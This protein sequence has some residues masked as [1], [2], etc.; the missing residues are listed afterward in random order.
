MI[1]KYKVLN[2]EVIQFDRYNEAKTDNEKMKNIMK[3]KL[4]SR[5]QKNKNLLIASISILTI[6]SGAIGISIKYPSFAEKI[7]VL[8]DMMYLIQ[9]AIQNESM[10][11]SVTNVNKSFSNDGLTFTV[12]KSWFTGNQ[13]YIDFTLK[14]EEPF[15]DTKYVDAL[16]D[17]IHIDNNPIPY[18]LFSKSDLYIDDNEIGNYS[19]EYARA[20]FINEYTMKSNILIDF[21]P[22]GLEFGNTANVKFSFKLGEFEKSTLDTEWKMDFD[23]KS[24]RTMYKKIRV[25]ENKNGVTI[26]DIKINQTSLNIDLKSNK[27]N[28][29]GYVQVQDDKGNI[30]NNGSALYDENSY[31]SISYLSDIGVIPEYIVVTVYGDYQ[32]DKTPVAE[33]KVNI[34]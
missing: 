5:K 21:M 24:N 27:N 3:S 34:Q 14:S 18:L 31:E 8:S 16:S 29:I 6:F 12:N 25:N 32:K 23:V 11:D 1:D 2:N 17:T 22:E 15:K 33:F 4:K 19:F 9:D 7:P 10:E 13:I 28:T 30:L 26:K 20:N